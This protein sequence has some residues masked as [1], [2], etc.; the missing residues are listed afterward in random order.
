MRLH[1]V[2][3]IAVLF[4]CISACCANAS[5]DLVGTNAVDLGKIYNYDK[6]DIE[7]KLINSGE[8]D[9]SIRDMISTCPCIF[10]IKDQ[11]IIKAGKKY[12]LKLHFNPRTVHGKFV[13]GVWLISS[14]KVNPKILFKVTG[15]VLPLFTGLPTEP[16]TLQSES[17]NAVFTNKFTITGVNPAYTLGTPKSSALNVK[18]TVNMEKD[19]KDPLTSHLTV[20]IQPPA[21][22]RMRGNI[23]IP[24]IG[25]EKLDGLKIDYNYLVGLQ[26]RASPSKLII[27]NPEKTISKRLYIITYAG[28]DNADD[29]KYEPHLDGITVEKKAYTR[30]SL[31]SR[32]STRTRIKLPTVSRHSSTSR[33]GCT[34]TI[35]PEA[36]KKIQ[37][38]KE[39]GL[40]FTYPRHK[41]VTIPLVSMT[42]RSAAKALNAVQQQ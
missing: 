1:V 15:K 18:L 33:F 10:G 19:K 21:G 26:L 7:F 5:L 29:L 27:T 39:P 9:I 2:N 8:T 20:I 24:V 32:V 37:K 36:Y 38:M 14:D 31:V 22:M 42:P 25:P 28:S 6:R 12:T 4:V 23:S 13:R 30:R 34:V 40:T 3:F 35:S 16:V 11:E 41:P 17:D